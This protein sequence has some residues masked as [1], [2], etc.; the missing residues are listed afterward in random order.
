MS[1][2]VTGLAPGTVFHY[3]LVATHGGINAGAGADMSFETF[4]RPVPRPRVTQRTTPRFQRG[5]P[6]VLATAGRVFNRTGTANALACTGVATVAFYIGRH[7]IER[8]LAPL[9]PTCRL[10]VTT[11]FAHLPLRHRRRVTLLVY[12]RFDGNGYLAP[13]SVAPERVTL[14]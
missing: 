9:T 12:V 3:A 14:G 8:Q 2:T 1:V 6:F 7:R 4:P 10:A 11:T 13:V 5:A